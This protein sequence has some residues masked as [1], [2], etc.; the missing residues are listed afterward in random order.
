MALNIDASGFFPIL[1][2]YIDKKAMFASKSKP[3]SSSACGIQFLWVRNCFLVF[4]STRMNIKEN[5]KT[6]IFKGHLILH[7]L[8]DI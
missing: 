5:G 7:D 4:R 2:I 3:A 1:R 6:A 8:F